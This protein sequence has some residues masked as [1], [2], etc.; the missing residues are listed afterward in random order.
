[1]YSITQV[2]QY[3]TSTIVPLK[4][5]LFTTLLIVEICNSKLFFSEFDRGCGYYDISFQ[6]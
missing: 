3:Y 4:N 2:P 1:M 5:K 6:G